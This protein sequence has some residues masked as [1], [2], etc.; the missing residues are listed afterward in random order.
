MNDPRRTRMIAMGSAALVDAFALVGF[1]TYP[2]ANA[3]TLEAVLD[4]LSKTRASALVILEQDLAR[5]Q[6]PALRR[7]RGEDPRIVIV[8]IPR[9]DAPEAYRPEVENLVATLLGKSALDPQP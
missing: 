8:E 7:A 6:G 3:E 5:S 9:L 1:E 2:D 4:G